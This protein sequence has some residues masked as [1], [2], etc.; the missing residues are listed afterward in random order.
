MVLTCLPPPSRRE[1]FR[2]RWIISTAR[3]ENQ[4]SDMTDIDVPADM[5]LTNLT[6]P[7]VRV[8]CKRLAYSQLREKLQKLHTELDI[9]HI[10]VD[11]QI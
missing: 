3:I 10:L 8:F 9:R 6:G 1:T 5:Y 2:A 4:D 11:T 7:S